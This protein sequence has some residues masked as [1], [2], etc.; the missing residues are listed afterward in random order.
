M[1]ILQSSPIP[2][3]IHTLICLFLYSRIFAQTTDSPYVFLQN[4]VYSIYINADYD[5][6]QLMYQTLESEHA[7]PATTTIISSI[8]SATMTCGFRLRGNTSLNAAKKSYRIS[9]DSFDN[10][11]DWRGLSDIN[12]IALHN[13]PSVM[14]SKLCYDLFRSQGIAAP[15]TSYAALYLNNQYI[16]V[17]Q[18]TEPINEIF[19]RTHIDNQGDGNLFKCTYPATLEFL[20]T[21]P[22]LYKFE[23]WGRRMYELKNN[24][25]LDDYTSFAEFISYIN[26]ESNDLNCYNNNPFQFNQYITCAAL[27]ILLGHWDNYIF[28][29]NNYYLYH[30][31][32]TDKYYYIPYDVDN[33][34]G[35]DWV[36][37]DWSQPNIYDF[38]PSGAPRPLYQAVL[39]NPESRNHFSN[40][41]LRLCNTVFHPD[42]ISQRISTITNLISPF[43]ASDPLYPMDYGFTYNDFLLSATESFGNQVTFG[44]LPY[45]TARRNS[46]LQQLETLTTDIPNIQY[47]Y[48]ITHSDYSEILGRI[49]QNSASTPL[50]VEVSF[51]GNAPVSIAI[52]YLNSVDFH[53]IINHPQNSQWLTYRIIQNPTDISCGVEQV[54]INGQTDAIKINELLC[55]NV[56][57][58]NDEFGEFDDWIELYNSSDQTVSLNG[59]FLTDDSVNWNRFALPNVSIPSQSYMIFWL[60][61]DPETGNYHGTFNLAQGETI[62]LNK[63]VDNL[64]RFIDSVRLDSC[65]DNISYARDQTTNEWFFSMPPTPGAYNNLNTSA[66]SIE[67]SQNVWIKDGYITLINPETIKVIDISGRVISQCDQ[68]QA[69]P[70]S[71]LPSGYYIIQTDSLTKPFYITHP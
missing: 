70:V 67:S 60:D 48:I 54:W 6:L 50:Q 45:V 9:F 12:L 29:K 27:E 40:E 31:E 66:S 28:N 46:A 24:Q 35:I 14:R 63:L 58:N 30:N 55:E 38:A 62:S 13:D 59:Y 8:D 20:G 25:W 33:T 43:V 71:Q 42:S 34:L 16:G 26:N 11:Q 53:A 19:C 4:E 2:F 23:M 18:M 3:C 17:Y 37:I 36:G 65:S 57:F 69:V 10:N 52:E 44:I 56:S 47:Q 51:D 41:I 21:D 7:F 64:P 61:N 68:C 1:K 22:D 32:L 39:N 15:R 49:E 5:S